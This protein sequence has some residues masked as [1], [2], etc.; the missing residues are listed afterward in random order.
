MSL[1]SSRDPATCRAATGRL[2]ARVS[3]WLFCNAQK[4]RQALTPSAYKFGL[5]RYL[6]PYVV[7]LFTTGL[8]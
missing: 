7:I 6:P 5:Y 2:S 8:F 4:G 3:D 1:R